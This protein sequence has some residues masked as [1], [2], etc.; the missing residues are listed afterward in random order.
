MA[1]GFL[2]DRV[3]IR[4]VFLPEFELA[5]PLNHPFALILSFTFLAESRRLWF[6]H[7]FLKL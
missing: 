7:Q 5:L 6:L 1:G 2:L 3:F 4:S